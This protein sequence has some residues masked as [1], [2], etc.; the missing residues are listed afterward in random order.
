MK[1][2]QLCGGPHGGA[3]IQVADGE[4]EIEYRAAVAGRTGVF[5]ATYVQCEEP[6]KSGDIHLWRW[7]SHKAVYR[8][9]ATEGAM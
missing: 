3:V 5:T 7:D 8:R 6:R 9:G 2:V 4:T 1:K